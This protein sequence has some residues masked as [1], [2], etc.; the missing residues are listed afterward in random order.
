MGTWPQ[1]EE[2]LHW[3]HL[4]L[5][6]VLI[7]GKRSSQKGPVRFKCVEKGHLC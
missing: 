4:E 3:R 5:S 2:H 7:P 6:F 1:E